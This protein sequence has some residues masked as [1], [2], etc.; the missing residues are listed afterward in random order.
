MILSESSVRAGV[1]L[2]KGLSLRKQLRTWGMFR[3]PFKKV[4]P[5]LPPCCQ[6]RDSDC[7]AWN[8]R[9]FT[10]LLKA[11]APSWPIPHFSPSGLAFSLVHWLWEMAG[12]GRVNSG[13]QSRG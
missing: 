11:Q 8:Q 7:K 4:R 6:Q 5:G 10:G 13:P 9:C 2:V 1:P 12:L 3:N